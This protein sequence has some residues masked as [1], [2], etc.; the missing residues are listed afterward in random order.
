MTRMPYLVGMAMSVLL[1]AN[2][3]AATPDDMIKYRK[4]VMESNG[5]LMSATNAIINKKV[6][7]DPQLKGYAQALASLNHGL[8]SLFP[9]GSQSQD[10]DALPEVWTKRDEFE[11]RAHDAEAKATEFAKAAATGKN[12]DASF[13]SLSEACKS[14]HKEFR[15]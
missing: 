3:Q 1:T 2:S 13:K 5:G 7:F 9:V 14:C 6:P 10:S 11:S 4:N 12:V 15:K 8:S